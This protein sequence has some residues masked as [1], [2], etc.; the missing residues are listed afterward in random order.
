VTNVSTTFSLDGGAEIRGDAIG[1]DPTSS[2]SRRLMLL[3]AGVTV[4]LTSTAAIARIMDWFPAPVVSSEVIRTDEGLA[5]TLEADVPARGAGY[6]KRKSKCP[7]C[8]AIV[9]V[10]EVNDGGNA[11]GKLAE[12]HAKST[13]GAGKYYEFTVRLRDGSKHVIT[14]ADPAAWRVGE[15]VNVIDSMTLSS[16]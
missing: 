9:S 10:R 11:G 12:A 4:I 3:I 5:T 13:A 1:V 14:D 2:K 15:R 16:R 7:G 8:G 6:G